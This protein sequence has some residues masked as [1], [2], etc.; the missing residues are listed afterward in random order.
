MT[1]E[2]KRFI[3]M[4]IVSQLTVIRGRN[5]DLIYLWF[6]RFEEQLK[7]E[8]AEKQK[9][10][11]QE[12]RKRN[13]FEKSWDVDNRDFFVWERCCDELEKIGKEGKE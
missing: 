11:I 2:R 4:D 5:E 6:S 10:Q 1:C 13:P 8:F 9:E 7:K 3:A 12:L